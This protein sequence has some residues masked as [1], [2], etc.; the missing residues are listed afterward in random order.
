MKLTAKQELFAQLVAQ[1][2]TQADAYR[3][4]YDAKRMKPQVL[5]VTASQ[6]AANPKVAIRVEELRAEAAKA[7]VVTME[8][9]MNILRKLRD[10]ATEAKQYSAAIKAEELAGKVSGFYIERHERKDVPAFSQP[11]VIRERQAQI[12]AALAIRKARERA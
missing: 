11:D 7:C 12:E 3:E 8:E 1:G 2:K 9:H 4:A 6:L 10:Q 5:W